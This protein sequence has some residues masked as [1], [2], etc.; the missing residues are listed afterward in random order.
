MFTSLNVNLHRELNPTM[1]RGLQWFI[2]L[3]LAIF[4]AIAILFYLIRFHDGPLEIL[5]G[6]PFQSGELV[7]SVEDWSFLSDELTIELQ[8]MLPP[9][10]RTMWLVVSDNR[11]FVISSYMNTKFGKV[12]KQWPHRVAEDSQAIVRVDSKLYEMRLIRHKQG[13]FVPQVLAKFGQKYG[14]KIDQTMVD[15]GSAWLFELVAR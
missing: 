12:W 1:S 9:R 6:G 11:I 7:E 2:G 10:S 13:D 4:V 5:S 8:T 15:S 14:N 3:V